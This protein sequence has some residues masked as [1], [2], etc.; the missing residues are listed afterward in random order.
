MPDE[1]LGSIA[2]LAEAAESLCHL[3]DLTFGGRVPLAQVRDAGRLSF[4]QIVPMSRRL[5]VIEDICQ[6]AAEVA[7]ARDRFRYAVAR[8]LHGEG[9]TMDEIALVL[10]VSRQRVSA[11]LQHPGSGGKP[12]AAGSPGRAAPAA[13]G[14][15]QDLL[16]RSYEATML[17]EAG[18][19]RHAAEGKRDAAQRVRRQDEV[20]GEPGAPVPGPHRLALEASQQPGAPL[21]AGG[22][23]RGGGQAGPPVSREPIEHATELRKRLGALAGEVATTEEAIA[24]T[25]DELAARRPQRASGFRHRAD[26]ARKGAHQAREIERKYRT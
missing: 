2:D 20:A 18:R 25:F 11:I 6:A 16:Q 8:S 13:E 17:R 15:R 24:Q 26:N 21:A 3:L 7:G 1:A 10:G 23:R 19:G 9:F 14:S 5:P 4:A 22:S 12:G